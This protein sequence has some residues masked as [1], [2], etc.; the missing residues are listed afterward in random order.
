M[1]P[2]GKQKADD[3]EVFV[4]VGCQPVGICRSFGGRVPAAERFS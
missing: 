1:K 4:V 3:V 2:F